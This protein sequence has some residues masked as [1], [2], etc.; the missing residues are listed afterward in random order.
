[1]F[2]RVGLSFCRAR[3]SL[4]PVRIK[5]SSLGITLSMAFTFPLFGS[6]EVLE[7]FDF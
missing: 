2:L 5:L 3:Q 1:M 6:F 4:R 7:E